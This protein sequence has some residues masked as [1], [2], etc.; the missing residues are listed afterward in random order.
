MND[1]IIT[2]VAWI[3]QQKKHTLLIIAVILIILVWG[4]DYGTGPFLSASIFYLAPIAF[5][6]WWL[7]RKWSIGLSFVSAAAWLVTDIITNPAIPNPFIPYWNAIVRL[8][9]S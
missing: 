5:S 6:A 2:V 8:G 4:I 1:L 3:E 7:D 9:F